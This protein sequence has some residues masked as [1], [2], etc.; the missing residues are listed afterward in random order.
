MDLVA[1]V[2]P[3]V[4][5]VCLRRRQACCRSDSRNALPRLTLCVYTLQMNECGAPPNEIMGEM[6]PGA[7]LAVPLSFFRILLTRVLS[8]NAGMDLGADGM[9]KVPECV[10]C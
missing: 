7:S 5:A 4:L 9:P 8:S 2:S 10:V 3:G 1:K 6:P